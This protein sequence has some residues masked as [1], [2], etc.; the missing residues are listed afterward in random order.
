MTYE[1]ALTDKARD[2]YK[3]ASPEIAKKLAR[4]FSTLEQ[5]PY[6]HPNI[7]ALKGN[8]SGFYRF[9]AGDYRVVDEVNEQ[10]KQVRVTNIAHRSDV[11]DA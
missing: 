10:S 11:Y 7:K 8:L 6:Q 4:C 5:T 2:F 1:I 3:F 9:R